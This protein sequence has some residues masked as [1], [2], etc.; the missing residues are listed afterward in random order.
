[1]RDVESAWNLSSGVISIFVMD[2]SFALLQ[3]TEESQTGH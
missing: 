2:Q 3:V 1:L